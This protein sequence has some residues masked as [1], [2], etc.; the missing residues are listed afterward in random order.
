MERFLLD[1][2]LGD[3]PFEKLLRER[4]YE[5]EIHMEYG[6]TPGIEWRK[7][8]WENVV[9]HPFEWREAVKPASTVWV[10]MDLNRSGSDDEFLSL[11]VPHSVKE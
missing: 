4:N 5:I 6:P 1:A 9:L 2:Y 11:V 3:E 7:V 8:E 10:E